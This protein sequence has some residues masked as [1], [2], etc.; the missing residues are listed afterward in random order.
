[1]DIRRSAGEMRLLDDRLLELL[2]ARAAPM[3][4]TE[5]RDQLAETGAG[6]DFAASYVGERLRALA[7]LGLVAQ[8]G[9][10]NRPIYT[11]TD[12]GSEY[13]NGGLDAETLSGD[14]E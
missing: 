4:P 2:A 1:M 7:D 12:A 10:D 5:C 13:L 3:G 8:H 6:L 14:A 11:V 9:T